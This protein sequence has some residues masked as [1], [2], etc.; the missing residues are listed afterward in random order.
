MSKEGKYFNFPVQLLDGFLSNTKKC[1]DDISRYA[2]YDR[3][4]ALEGTPEAKFKSASSYLEIQFSDNKQAIKSGRELHDS[5]DFRSPKAGINVRVWW[6]FYKNDKPEFEKVCLLAFLALKSIAQQ[7]AYCKVTNNYLFARMDGKTHSC[8]FEQLSAGIRKYTND[9]QAR[10]IKRELIDSWGLTTYS[11]Y[12]RGFY[13][14]F[15]MKLEDLVLQAETK[16]KSVKEKQYKA[17]EQLAI[18]NAL[19]KIGA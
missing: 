14:S 1:L 16:R 13:I 10:R 8:E 18:K 11:R 4:L 2:V 5:I 3:S 12:T 6:D 9:Y 19:A 15:T 7:K 17:R